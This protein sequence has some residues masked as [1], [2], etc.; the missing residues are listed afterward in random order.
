MHTP[1]KFGTEHSDARMS[2]STFSTPSLFTGGA[3]DNFLID[4]SSLFPKKV[5]VEKSNADDLCPC[6][7]S[8]SWK[9]GAMGTL[10]RLL[11]N[12][13]WRCS[14]YNEGM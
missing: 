13:R 5:S 2:A 8:C 9:L 14:V 6:L 7:D 10:G 4:F 12:L 1:L 3:Q 11:E